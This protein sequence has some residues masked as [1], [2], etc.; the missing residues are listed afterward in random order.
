LPPTDSSSFSGS[1][2]D[3]K[4]PGMTI[5]TRMKLSLDDGGCCESPRCVTPMPLARLF[6][7]SGGANCRAASHMLEAI[8][9]Q[10][11]RADTSLAG[12]V[13]HRNGE[14]VLGEGPKGRHRIAVDRCVGPLGLRGTRHRRPGPYDPGT[15]CAGPAGLRQ[16][17]LAES[18]QRCRKP[19]CCRFAHLA[20]A[21]RDSTGWI[22]TDQQRP[23]EVG[24]I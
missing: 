14:K 20:F 5:W 13:S 12:G 23:V 22:V 11:R 19:W 17:L 18:L 3:A 15:N 7:W 10:A 24:I 16:R 6:P 4:R 2:V 1:R 21:N 9:H 8:H